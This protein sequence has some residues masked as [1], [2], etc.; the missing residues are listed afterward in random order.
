MADKPITKAD[1]RYQKRKEAVDTIARG[2]SVSSVP[3]VLGI[4]LSHIVPMVGA[5]SPWWL[6]R[7]TEDRRSGRPR[8]V[9][10]EVMQWLYQA[11]TLGDPQH[12]QSPSAFGRS[13]SSERC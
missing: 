10:G 11:I 8:K 4:P 3:R 2:E 9:T 1:L 12:H 6:S 7:V 5:V 13:Q